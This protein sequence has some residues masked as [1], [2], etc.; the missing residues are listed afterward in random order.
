MPDTQTQYPPVPPDD[1]NRSMASANPDHEGK[2]PH[3]GLVGDTYTITIDGEDTKGRFCLVDMHIPPGG[4]PGPHRHN[5][6]ETFIVLNGEIEATFR[7]KKSVVHA[8]ETVNIPANAPH[9]F[10]NTSAN[11]ARLLC[12]CSPAGQEKFFLEVGVPVATRTTAPPKLDDQQMAAF[13]EKAKTLAPK[14]QTELL[15]EA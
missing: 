6:E 4:G 10:H 1:L 15:R 8:G 9:M 11:P 2:L 13:L 5:F 14:Y 3:I 7:G 12:I